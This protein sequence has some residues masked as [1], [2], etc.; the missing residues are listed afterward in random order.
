MKARKSIIKYLF[1]MLSRAMKSSSDSIDRLFVIIVIGDEVNHRTMAVFNSSEKRS[2]S[3]YFSN[4]LKE[5]EQEQKNRTYP[6]CLQVRRSRYWIQVPDLTISM[7]MKVIKGERHLTLNGLKSSILKYSKYT[8]MK[9][10]MIR[11]KQS[12]LLT[13][14]WK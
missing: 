2:V 11:T 9:Y 8:W 13:T 4:F 1:L 14:L 5:I 10:I 7:T 3:R 6:I 12:I